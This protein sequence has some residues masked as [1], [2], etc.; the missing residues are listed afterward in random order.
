[1]ESANSSLA[2]PRILCA[3]GKRRLPLPP[4]CEE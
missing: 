4:P 2:L 1:M 3:I